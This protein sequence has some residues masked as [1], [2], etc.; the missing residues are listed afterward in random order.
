MDTTTLE[1]ANE[2]NRRIKEFSE[3]LNCFEWQPDCDEN[4]KSESFTTHPQLIIEFDGGE[5]RE[6]VA[7][8]MKLSDTLIDFLK[9][10][11]KKELKKSVDE[12]N[13]L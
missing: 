12:F 3:A 1:K 13:A 6:Q 7:L 4:R 8:S 5:D 10:E 11:I 2:L 9:T